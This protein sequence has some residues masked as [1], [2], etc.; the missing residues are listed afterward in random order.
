MRDLILYH[1]PDCHLCDDAEA[2]LHSAGLHG[3]YEKVDIESD[4]ELMKR[5]GIYV[6]VIALKANGS[7]LFWPFD[8]AELLAFAGAEE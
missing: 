7:E 6:P 5:Y 3:R 1:H 8:L 2:L 4:P